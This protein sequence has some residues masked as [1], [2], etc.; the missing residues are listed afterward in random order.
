MTSPGDVARVMGDNMDTNF[1]RGA[2]TKFG[3]A[4]NIQNLARFLTITFDIESEYLRNGS[5]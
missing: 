1:G 3:R 4:K 5:L 2:P